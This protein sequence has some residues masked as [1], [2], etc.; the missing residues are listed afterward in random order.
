MTQ[1][2]S[3]FQLVLLNTLSWFLNVKLARLNFGRHAIQFSP[4]RKASLNAK[5]EDNQDILQFLKIKFKNLFLKCCLE[6]RRIFWT[7]WIPCSQLMI[8]THKPNVRMEREMFVFHLLLNLKKKK[9]GA[10]VLAH[11]VWSMIFVYI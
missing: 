5:N 7:L 2:H 1:N 11:I 4:V 8:S 3:H 6:I 9:H 10:N